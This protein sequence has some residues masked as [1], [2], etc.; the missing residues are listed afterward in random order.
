[1][2]PPLGA[3]PDGGHWQPPGPWR[4]PRRPKTRSRDTW[5][6]P[7]L[8]GPWSQLRASSPASLS[9]LEWVHVCLAERGGSTLLSA[10]AAQTWPL[11][12]ATAA[13]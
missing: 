3:E 7:D 11:C 1:A 10:H 2:R 13:H 6:P 12:E 5:A 9:A 4:A 8:V